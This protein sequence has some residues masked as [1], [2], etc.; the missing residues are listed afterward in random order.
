MLK[1]PGASVV[2]AGGPWFKSRPASGLFKF[3]TLCEVMT[4]DRDLYF[5]LF[6]ALCIVVDNRIADPQC[7][8][9]GYQKC[10]FVEQPQE[11]LAIKLTFEDKEKELKQ[12]M[13]KKERQIHLVSGSEPILNFQIKK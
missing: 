8:G 4:K 12:K 10:A 3:Y 9:G 7:G 11:V 2:G 5:S 6:S 1:C 13:K